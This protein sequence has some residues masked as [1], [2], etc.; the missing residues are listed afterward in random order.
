LRKWWRCCGP[1]AIRGGE[2]LYLSCGGLRKGGEHTAERRRVDTWR[3]LRL[4]CGGGLERVGGG[5]R[6][7][8]RPDRLGLIAWEGVG[9][10]AS[11]VDDRDGDL[12]H[13]LAPGHVALAPEAAH[14]SARGAG[15]R[16]ER[17][18]GVPLVAHRAVEV[19]VLTG[20]RG[21][22]VEG[23]G[24][25]GKFK[26]FRKRTEPS[27]SSPGALHELSKM[28]HSPLLAHAHVF[29]APCSYAIA[30]PLSRV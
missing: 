29:C 9:V 26:T 4:G 1:S 13:G 28:S 15:R 12:G 25:G 7:D 30:G 14:A 3:T 23:G 22:W 19:D 21:G 5:G 27:S 2:S 8:A 17:A 20:G 24:G 11:R 6:G 16:P 18:A 10:G